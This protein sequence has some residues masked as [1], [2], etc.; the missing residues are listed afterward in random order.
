[1]SWLD[2]LLMPSHV[3]SHAKC[4]SVGSLCFGQFGVCSLDHSSSP[5][6]F[7]RCRRK[8]SAE[9]SW[10]RRGV[11]S[12]VCQL[13]VIYMICPT[14]FSCIL[15]SSDERE[16]PNQRDIGSKKRDLMTASVE[17]LNGSQMFTVFSGRQE[18]RK[19]KEEVPFGSIRII[20]FVFR[21]VQCIGFRHKV[22]Q[23]Y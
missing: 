3:A 8:M 22:A 13:L 20:C 17:P 2:F 14:C 4:T 9:E 18:V 21:F 5:A 15:Y 6:F 10:R 1:M 16:P 7:G 11:S 23:G 12:N 19:K